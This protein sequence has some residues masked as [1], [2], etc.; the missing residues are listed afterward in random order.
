MKEKNK[1]GITL[2]ALVVTIIIL[3]ILVGV[4]FRTITGENGM[5]SRAEKSAFV[6]KMGAYK[7]QVDLYASW[8]ITETLNTNIQW[9]NS[10]EPLKIAIEQEVVSD[11]KPEDVNIAIEEII[12][13]I[14]EEEKE[15]LVVYKG[16]LYYV[17]NNEIPDNERKAK[18]CQQV[19]I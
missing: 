17:W 11:I 19:G 14:T 5:F 1:K 10:G 7:E 13:S 8:Q 6:A 2:I 3:L 15:Y 4:I 9:I 16:E 12:D 18:W